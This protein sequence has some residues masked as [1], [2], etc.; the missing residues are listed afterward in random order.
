[1]HTRMHSTENPMGLTVA[2]YNLQYTQTISTS[3]SMGGRT[4]T[5]VHNLLKHRGQPH[6][7]LLTKKQRR[8]VWSSLFF[9]TAETHCVTG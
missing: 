8:K 4:Q 1:M 3:E 9:L 7:W 2:V 6:I 5:V